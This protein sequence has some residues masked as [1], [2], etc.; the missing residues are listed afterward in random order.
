[1][2]SWPAFILPA[3]LLV[4][5]CA[6]FPELD[7]QP[8]A[9]H[10]AADFQVSPDLG[11]A[12]P[13]W[14]LDFGDPALRRMLAEADG[15]GLDAASARVRF[16]AA[17]LALDQVRATHAQAPTAAFGFGDSTASL[18]ASLGYEPD[19]AGR[20]DAALRAA[21]LDHRASGLDALIAR[22]TLAR[23]V[24]QG[25]VG[26][27][28]AR[29]ELRRTSEVIDAKQAAIAI[30][31]QR[32]AAGEITGADLA[33][34]EHAL[35][36]ARADAVGARGAVAVAAARL[37][38][39]GVQTV[40]DAISLRSATRPDL[41]E[42][43]DLAA[44]QAIPAVCIAW[45]RFHAADARRA[46]TLAEARP[47]LVV[48]SSLSA[49]ASTLAS[50]I[51]GNAVA[52]ANTVRLEGAILDNGAARRRLDQGRLSVAQSE[53]DWLQ[54]RN[55]AEIAALAAVTARH[56]AEAAL[57]VALMAWLASQSDLDRVRAR[58][59]AG[60]ADALD[61]IEAESALASAQS[62]VDR[63][64]AEAFLAAAALYGALQS[65][66]AGCDITPAP[67]PAQSM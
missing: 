8:V 2:R 20:F 33:A 6:A 35:I 54:A 60:L 11:D 12:A 40:P 22:R 46:E 59:A 5:A 65:G 63:S 50:L 29:T 30:L 55:Q 25:W 26:L 67:A 14:A 4:S 43:T 34:R 10:R 61:L 27:A 52:L 57:D 44:T 49:T 64:R 56:S 28:V 31:R 36:R 37:H 38:A 51:S 62:D 18:T 32:R 23:E 48:T 17:D 9:A 16:R 58:Q 15:G 53:I 7:G 41:P 24:T 13:V 3:A 45:L 19:L 39:L 42:R 47:R 21:T 1:M 66:L